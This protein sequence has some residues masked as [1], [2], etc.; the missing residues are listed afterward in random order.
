MKNL[1]NYDAVLGSLHFLDS[2][3]HCFLKLNEVD[4]L[5]FYQT[6]WFKMVDSNLFQIAAHFD[7]FALRYKIEKETVD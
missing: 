1:E 5:K 3:E 7:F 4:F 6:Q 2:S